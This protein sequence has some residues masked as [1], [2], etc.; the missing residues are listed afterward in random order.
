MSIRTSQVLFG[1]AGARCI[2]SRPAAEFSAKRSWGRGSNQPAA[3]PGRSSGGIGLCW[4]WEKEGRKG[5]REGWREWGRK[6]L[7]HHSPFSSSL[8]FY[9]LAKAG[10]LFSPHSVWWA[11]KRK[12][13]K[14]SNYTSVCFTHL[15]LNDSLAMC[16]IRDILQDVSAPLDNTQTALGPVWTNG[17][18]HFHLFHD[19]LNL[20]IYQVA[21]RK[22]LLYL[23][24]PAC[25][26]NSYYVYMKETVTLVS[27]S[28]LLPS[29]QK[30]SVPQS[31]L[32]HDYRRA[33]TSPTLS[34]TPRW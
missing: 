30:P 18:K 19:L 4:W 14:F 27:K 34:M 22:N 32:V 12:K 15:S 31:H 10:F 3:G 23:I 29:L 6:Q 33:I 11:K 21:K 26:Y 9:F 1:V 25:S 13:K 16:T 7:P 5:G 8:T 17:R 2:W 20:H 24:V 28:G